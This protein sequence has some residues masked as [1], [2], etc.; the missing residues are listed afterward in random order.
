[1]KVLSVS[2]DKKIEI[3]T[4]IG[5]DHHIWTTRDVRPD[6]E[7]PVVVFQIGG[8]GCAGNEVEGLPGDG[9]VR[10]DVLKGKVVE[11]DVLG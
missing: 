1:M 10:V 3:I 6:H 5:P 4:K 9:L 11:D 8:D 2:P 7:C